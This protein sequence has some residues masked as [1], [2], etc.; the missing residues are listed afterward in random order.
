MTWMFLSPVFWYPGQLRETIGEGAEGLFA[1]NPLYPLLQAHRL[2]LGARDSVT[3]E[4]IAVQFGDVFT[5]LGAASLW[6]VVFL[7]IGYGV[8]RSRQH[9]FADLV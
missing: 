1:W 5:H 3:A 7:A 4:G 6:A 9:K 2:V 8:F